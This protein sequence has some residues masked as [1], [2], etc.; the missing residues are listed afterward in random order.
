M[1]YFCSTSVFWSDALQYYLELLAL[2]TEKIT[3]RYTKKLFLRDLPTKMWKSYKV[4]NTL[5]LSNH[6][7][8]LQSASY[9]MYI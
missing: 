9:I 6:I 2:L 1:Y 5:Q 3:L 8:I 4:S 7:Y